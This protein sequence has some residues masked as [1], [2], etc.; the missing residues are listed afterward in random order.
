MTITA[1]MDALDNIQPTK[2][3]IFLLDGK[4]KNIICSK[5]FPDTRGF[6]GQI[7][8]FYSHSYTADAVYNYRNGSII[9]KMYR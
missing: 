6:T 3:Y 2:K 7:R 5:T 9:R 4:V 1:V 8:M